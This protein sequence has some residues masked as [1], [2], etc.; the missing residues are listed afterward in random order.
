MFETIIVQPIF[1]MLMLIYSAIPGGDF[2]ITLIIFTIL[3]RFLLYPL[4]KRQ[5]HQTKMMRKLQPELKKIKQRAKGDRQAEAMAMME[6]YKRHGVS[7]FRSIGILLIQLPIFI[8][9]YQVIQI[10]TLRR[11]E[12]SRHMYD[13]LE[14]IGPVQHL[15]QNPDDFNQKMLGFIDLTKT[16]FADGS[17]DITLVALALISAVTQYIMSKQTMPNT[18]PPKKLRQILSEAAAG[19][20]HDQA[21]ANAAVMNSMIKFM[22]FVMFFIMVSVP[23]ALALYFTISNLVAVAQQHFLLNKDEEELED[24]A[25]EAVERDKKAQEKAKETAAKTGKRVKKAQEAHITR[26]VA[27]DTRKRKKEKRS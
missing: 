14:N 25:E 27:N 26:I 9:L 24:L 1:N 3:I 22:P 5:L 6:L 18:D 15:I 17:V 20:Q 11:E 23:G 4:V 19:K 7:P 8:G 10:M 16:A 12:I 21:D 13:F 2:G